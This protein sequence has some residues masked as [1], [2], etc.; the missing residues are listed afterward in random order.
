MLWQQEDAKE[1]GKKEK[2]KEKK[3]KKDKKGKKGK[4][5]KDDE[6]RRSNVNVQLTGILTMLSDMIDK[7]CGHVIAV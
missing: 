7:P 6:V 5:G 4:K 1:G 3:E 2:K